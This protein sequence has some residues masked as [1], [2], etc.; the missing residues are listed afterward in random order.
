MKPLRQRQPASAAAPGAGA[1]RD[2]RE[3][4]QEEPAWLAFYLVLDGTLGCEHLTR[5]GA[6]RRVIE[7]GNC[8]VEQPLVPKCPAERHRG[9]LPARPQ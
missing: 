4:T 7:V 9:I 1:D 8:R 5:R 3:F 6:D 2:R